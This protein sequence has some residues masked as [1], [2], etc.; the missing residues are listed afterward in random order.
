MSQVAFS[1]LPA[2][3][4]PC[5]GWELIPRREVPGEKGWQSRLRLAPWIC[6]HAAGTSRQAHGAEAVW[7]LSFC[8]GLRSC[9]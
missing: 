9:G 7:I 5:P 1:F 8:E 6:A 3:G 4:I 2:W